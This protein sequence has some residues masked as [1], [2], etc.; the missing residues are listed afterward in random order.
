MCFVNFCFR[1]ENYATENFKRKKKTIS[2][3]HYILLQNL[4][5][6]KDYPLLI[7]S[8]NSYTGSECP[9]VQNVHVLESF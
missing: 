8:T 7:L 1:N 6:S 2:R 4:C 5:K 9:S 3:S